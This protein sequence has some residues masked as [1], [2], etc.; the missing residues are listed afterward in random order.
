M[1]VSREEGDSEEIY[2]CILPTVEEALKYVAEFLND[3][4]KEE[5]ESAFVL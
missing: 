4:G 2:T 3:A 5:D 1:Q